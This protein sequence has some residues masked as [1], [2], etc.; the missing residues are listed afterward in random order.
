MGLRRLLPWI[1]IVT[2]SHNGNLSPVLVSDATPLH[3][4]HALLPDNDDVSPTVT[5]DGFPTVTISTTVTATTSTTTTTPN[6]GHLV[7]SFVLDVVWLVE[8]AACLLLSCFFVRKIGRRREWEVTLRMA[9]ISASTRSGRL[10]QRLYLIVWGE[11]ILGKLLEALAQL[12]AAFNFVSFVVFNSEHVGAQYGTF[13]TKWHSFL[14]YAAIVTYV[15]F[16]TSLLLRIALV[17][18]HP[19]WTKYPPRWSWYYYVT[20]HWVTV[21]ELASFIPPMIECAVGHVYVPSLLWFRLLRL[22]DNFFHSPLGVQGFR[23]FAPAMQDNWNILLMTYGTIGIFWVML[24]TCYWLIEQHNPVFRWDNIGWPYNRYDNIPSSMFYTSLNFVVQEHPL[25]GMRSGLHSVILGRLCVLLTFILGYFLFAIPSGV[26]GSSFIT[27]SKR[28]ASRQMLGARMHPPVLKRRNTN[29]RLHAIETVNTTGLP[30]ELC[31]FKALRTDDGDTKRWLLTEKGEL[32][33]DALA[34]FKSTWMKWWICLLSIV[35]I[36]N[37]MVCTVEHMGEFATR[38]FATPQHNR[39]LNRW[40]YSLS[41]HGVVDI[42]A[43]FPAFVLI[44][45]HLCDIMDSPF[46]AY[47]QACAILRIFKVD[48]YIRSY[49][50]IAH[51]MMEKRAI[52]LVTACVLMIL[53]VIFSVLMFYTER[54]NPDERT[55]LNYCSMYEALWSVLI[56]LTG[57][58]PWADF[59]SHGRALLVTC[60]FTATFAFSVFLSIMGTGFQERLERDH[61]IAQNQKFVLR[62]LTSNVSSVMNSMNNDALSSGEYDDNEHT[63]C[64]SPGICVSSNLPGNRHWATLSHQTLSFADAMIRYFPGKGARGSLRGRLYDFYYVPQSHARKS[65]IGPFNV[66]NLLRNLNIVLVVVTLFT[67]AL[68]N[69]TTDPAVSMKYMYCDLVCVSFFLIQWALRL[70]SYPRYVFSVLGLVDII[71]IVHFLYLFI[72]TDYYV[73]NKEYWRVSP[74][75][76]AL[77]VVGF[78]ITVPPQVLRLTLLDVFVPSLSLCSRVIWKNRGPLVN[79]FFALIPLWLCAT[80]LLYLFERGNDLEDNG[81]KMSDRYASI[82]TALPLT[83]VHLTGDYP[84]TSYTAPSR[85]LHFFLMFICSAFVQVPAAIFAASF[86]EE[87]KPKRQAVHLPQRMNRAARK[88]QLAWRRQSTIADRFISVVKEKVRANHAMRD[89]VEKRKIESPFAWKCCQVLRS[90][91]FRRSVNV[92]TFLNVGMGLYLSLSCT[93]RTCFPGVAIVIL[94]SVDAVLLLTFYFIHVMA[95]KVMSKF[96]CQRRR[97][98]QQIM[99]IWDVLCIGLILAGTVHFIMHDSRPISRD[100]LNVVVCGM[101]WRVILILEWPIFQ[102]MRKLLRKVWND[103]RGMLGASLIFLLVI[104]QYGSVLFYLSENSSPEP[105]GL[106]DDNPFTSLP[107]SMYFSAIFLF[108]EWTFINFTTLGN[109]VCCIYCLFGLTV[110]SI[111]MGGIFESLGNAMEARRKHLPVSDGGN[112]F[113]PLQSFRSSCDSVPHSAVSS[114]LLQSMPLMPSFKEESVELSEIPALF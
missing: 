112:S 51:I 61:K 56:H 46:Y 65:K 77:K 9:E 53:W 58:V 26:L 102:G 39:F 62:K 94:A 66:F 8:C 50:T 76:R 32:M 87:L 100:C 60:I 10:I 40:N 113:A 96:Q 89:L 110:F 28:N 44:I 109:V 59:T 20:R 25:A 29:L 37:Y 98:I 52:F 57:E 97:C 6:S 70:F 88:I 105:H 84:V 22:A 86:A 82:P 78:F 91:I 17:K 55:R 38:L 74:F 4:P 83:L 106:D 41:G 71:T 43:G 14:S 21:F 69:I 101:T 24:S 72:N 75:Q 99:R 79:A 93:D 30:A 47:F 54:I 67:M 12:A 35:G 1:S 19:E 15:W 11:S 95:A 85:V 80:T 64:N 49:E 104:W 103:V 111:P 36:I 73:N 34:M 31:D 114:S 7:K 45:F 48:R 63:G 3:A 92:V 5:T 108:G 90:N 16:L 13:D 27:A 107:S 2:A 18:E 33:K 68:L 81:R 23:A 42:C